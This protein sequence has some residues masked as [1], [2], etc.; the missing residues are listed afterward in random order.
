MRP[1]WKE[2]ELKQI[3]I[4]QLWRDLSGDVYRVEDIY[5]GDTAILMPIT[6]SP[7]MVGVRRLAL[8]YEYDGEFGPEEEA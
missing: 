7:I 2:I 5:C 4:G 3:K 6:P 1:E 8:D